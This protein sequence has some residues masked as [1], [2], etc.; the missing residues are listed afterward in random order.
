MSLGCLA[1][2]LLGCSARQVP[3][4]PS[5]VLLPKTLSAG[6]RLGVC[7]VA[8]SRGVTSSPSWIIRPRPYRP[9][10]SLL[11][12]FFLAMFWPHASDTPKR[13]TGTLCLQPDLFAL[14][15][16][17]GHLF[18]H[19]DLGSGP[20]KVK[21]PRKRLA[22]GAWHEVSVSRAGREGRITIDGASAE[23]STPGECTTPGLASHAV[24]RCRSETW[25]RSRTR[26]PNIVVF[27]LD[28]R[29]KYRAL[30]A[31]ADNHAADNA[32]RA[33]KWTGHFHSVPACTQHRALPGG[34]LLLEARCF[35]YDP[36][37]TFAG[38]KRTEDGGQKGW[39]WGKGLLSAAASP[40][41]RA[42]QGFP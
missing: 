5:R 18:L 1:A 11:P 28:W 12:P 39:G 19:L 32:Q 6:A 13:L 40:T 16:V 9:H 34:R 27:M 41:G 29:G 8:A 22:D 15:L 36:P 21:A 24:C 20:L 31:A 3:R 35:V 4:T 17:D 2:W 23:F 42:F 33:V 25:T 7:V 14:E 30:F 10:F 37:S 38:T 26:E